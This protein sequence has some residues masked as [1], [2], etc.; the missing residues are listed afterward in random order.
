[1]HWFLWTNIFGMIYNFK[2]ILWQGFHG[3]AIG[4]DRVDVA[5]GQGGGANY[6]AMILT[7][8]IPFLYMRILNGSWNQ[9]ERWLALGLMP[10]YVIGVVLTGSRGGFMSLVAVAFYMLARSNKKLI[11][12]VVVSLLLVVFVVTMP[13]AQIERFKQGLGLEGQERDKSASSRLR[14]WGAALRM[15]NEHPIK[16]VGLD[17]YQALSPRYVGVFAGKGEIPYQPGMMGRGFVTHSTWLQSL[18]EGGLL[19]SVPFFGMFA[20]SYYQLRKV[21]KVPLRG[22]IK[23]R[24]TEHAI[25]LEGVMLA[26]IVSS[27]FGSHFKIDFMWWYFGAIAALWIIAQKEVADAMKRARAERLQQAAAAPSPSAARSATVT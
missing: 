6:I 16:G 17:N 25:T 3:D 7:M 23:R 5:V 21:K 4:E 18:A 2:A 14:L 22:P 15:F 12:A 10:F 24:L 20:L 8:S 26:F 19:M 1:M 9:W 13:E 11:G 27:F